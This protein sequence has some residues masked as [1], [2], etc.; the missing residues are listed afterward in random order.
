LVE[1]K[2]EQPVFDNFYLVAFADLKK[3]D[4]YYKFL[5]PNILVEDVMTKGTHNLKESLGASLQ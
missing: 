4:Y 5:Y 3:H 1:G 2:I